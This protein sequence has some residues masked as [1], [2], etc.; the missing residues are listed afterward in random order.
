M[1]IW[2][3]CETDYIAKIGCLSLW[4]NGCSLFYQL[5]VP[6]L[7]LCLEV[8]FK[9]MI[10]PPEL[11]FWYHFQVEH[12]CEI[13]IL[14]Q[15]RS[16]ESY[17]RRTFPR[18]LEDPLYQ[19]VFLAFSKSKRIKVLNN[20]TVE[21]HQTSMQNHMQLYIKQ[22]NSKLLVRKLSSL[23]LNA[24]VNFQEVKSNRTIQHLLFL[25]PSVQLRI[26]LQVLC[27]DYS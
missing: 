24:N 10:F 3:H 23:S 22:N 26:P 15:F 21:S 2:T 14:K 11:I 20:W 6:L 13:Y 9:K 25:W 4:C 12:M 18:C 5:Q 8:Q 17:I 27:Q 19:E 7:F 1:A 16:S